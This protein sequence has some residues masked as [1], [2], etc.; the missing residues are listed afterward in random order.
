MSNLSV[1]VWCEQGLLG[2]VPPGLS[3]SL[4]QHPGDPALCGLRAVPRLHLPVHARPPG[5]QEGPVLPRRGGHGEVS[6]QGHALSGSRTCACLPECPPVRACVQVTVSG[7]EASDGSVRRCELCGGS[8]VRAFLS[9]AGAVAAG[10][11]LMEPDRG[12][13]S[14]WFPLS[15]QPPWTSRR[16]RGFT[17]G[18]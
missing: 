5:L 4:P 14:V 15:G 8:T 2:Q 10:S 1:S 16:N 9:D 7:R 12:G 17:G 11:A 18:R 6:A 3:T 13:Q